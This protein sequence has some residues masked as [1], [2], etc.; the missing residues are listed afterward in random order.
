[1][2]ACYVYMY[3][4]HFN[5]SLSLALSLSIVSMFFCFYFEFIFCLGLFARGLDVK[6]YLSTITYFVI[7]IYFLFIFNK[8]L[9]VHFFILR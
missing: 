1:M 4:L 7:L 8:K 3:A 9:L 5:L 2:H 6:R